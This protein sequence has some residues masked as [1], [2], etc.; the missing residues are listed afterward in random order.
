MCIRDRI[1]TTAPEIA[2]SRTTVTIPPVSSIRESNTVTCLVYMRSPGCPYGYV[3]SNTG[4]LV[5][6]APNGETYQIPVN[7]GSYVVEP[8]GSIAIP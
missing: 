7:S 5:V 4:M 8:D 2:T 3:D 6:D 1:T